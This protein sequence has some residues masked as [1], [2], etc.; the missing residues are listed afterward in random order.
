MT[1]TGGYRLNHRG[2][3]GGGVL[4]TG[5]NFRGENKLC[6]HPLWRFLAL[7]LCSN[8]VVCVC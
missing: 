6:L 1:L 8:V 7:R 4:V 3:V 5:F 2:M